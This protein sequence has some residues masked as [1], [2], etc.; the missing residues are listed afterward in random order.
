[1]VAF[2]SSRST[3]VL[4]SYGQATIPDSSEIGISKHLGEQSFRHHLHLL[5]D[6]VTENEIFEAAIVHFVLDA[7]DERLKVLRVENEFG[8]VC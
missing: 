6:C 4:W 8:K 2:I 7:V 5:A 3:H 1:M